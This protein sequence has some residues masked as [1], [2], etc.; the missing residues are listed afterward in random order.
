[1]AI[2]IDK[3]AFASLQ[4]G[5]RPYLAVLDFIR[6][7]IDQGRLNPGDRLP[8]QRDLA[9]KLGLAVGTVTKAYSEAARQRLVST[10]VGRG[11][12]VLETNQQGSDGGSGGEPF[13]LTFNHVAYEENHQN[14]LASGLNKIIKRIARPDAFDYDP[15]ADLSPDC[16]HAAEWLA[17]MGH[18]ADASRIVICNGVQHGLS[19]VLHSLVRSGAVVMTEE[20]GYPGIGLLERVL[21]FKLRGVEIDEGGLKMDSLRRVS[22]ETGARLLV[23][24]PTLH[25]P[26]N[27]ILALERR[28]NL[29]EIAREYDLTVIEYDVNGLPV[30]N[31]LPS[32]TVLAPERSFFITSTWK[33][34]G[35]GAALG[36]IVSPPAAVE[37]LNTVRQATTWTPS[38]LLREVVTAWLADG[39]AA[40]IVAWHKGEI[41]QR[42]DLAKE[43]FGALNLHSHPASYNLWLTLPEPWRREIFF[44]ALRSQGVIVSPADVFVVGRSIAPHAVRLSL[45][46]IR[47]QANLAKA[48][49]LAA[50]VLKE[51][52]QPRMVTV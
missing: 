26:T 6:T 14:E 47:D 52:P 7:E 34:T 28:Q 25:N 12:F 46:G 16:E 2:S 38:P 21:G 4:K 17:T 18:E 15:S 33:A 10:E 39:T 31:P 32:L 22:R 5:R 29:V 36:Y 43:A 13:E 37:R 50:E 35:L 3:E 51:G 9:K 24:A 44:D 23:C 48:L 45:G 30:D 49:S 42:L 40:R 19:L 1:M 27:S 8:P 20:L 11:T 41:A